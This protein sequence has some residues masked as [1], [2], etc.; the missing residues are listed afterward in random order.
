MGAILTWMT[1][2]L[3]S[4]LASYMT[5]ALIVL[6]GL[7]FGLLAWNKHDL[8]LEIQ[9]NVALQI[10]VDQLTKVVASQKQ[11]ITKIQLINQTLTEAERADSKQRLGK[12]LRGLWRFAPGTAVVCRN[13]AGRAGAAGGLC[14]RPQRDQ[15]R[16]GRALP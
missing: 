16:A 8:K 5:I 3:G 7:L 10:S 13:A 14:P 2:K 4:T 1:G 6:V 11:D 9:K 12:V 15:R